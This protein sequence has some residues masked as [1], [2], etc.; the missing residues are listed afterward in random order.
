MTALE[1]SIEPATEALEA[2]LA[3]G[4]L[5]DAVFRAVRAT[6]DVLN[7]LDPVD[8]GADAVGKDDHV[9]ARFSLRLRLERR[10]SSSLTFELLTAIPTNCTAG[11]MPACWDT[12]IVGTISGI[13]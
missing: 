8:D 11:F 1:Q 2:T 3:R 9:K 4:L 10:T 5:D 12:S 13:G 7:R 6:K